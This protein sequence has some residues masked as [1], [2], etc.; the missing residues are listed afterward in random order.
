[1]IYEVRNTFGEI[2]PYVL[3]VGAGELTAA[4][5]RQEQDKTFY[6]SPFIDMAMR[7]HFRVTPPG[8]I[9]RLRILE[10]DSRRPPARRHLL[11]PPPRAELSLA[12]DSLRLAAAGDTQDL[13]GDPLGSTAALGQGRTAR[14]A[15]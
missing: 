6:V 13:R 3:P 12:A 7:Y 4:G 1:M 10:T 5:L 15:R 9:V 8:D 2:K 11:R 14:P